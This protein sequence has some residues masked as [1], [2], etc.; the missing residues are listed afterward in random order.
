MSV[1]TRLNAHSSF[2]GRAS[3]FAALL[4]AAIAVALLVACDGGEDA[5]KTVT[6]TVVPSPTPSTVTPI[7]TPT[8]E[9]PT[10]PGS[11]AGVTASSDGWRRIDLSWTA[12]TDDGGSDVTGY[13]IEMSDDGA[14]WDELVADT[15][16]ESTEYAHVGL[17]VDTKRHY[18][19]SAINAVGVGSSS[20]IATGRAAPATAPHPPSDLKATKDEERRIDLSW[21]APVEDGGEVIIGYL[22][23]V[24][25]DG[26]DWQELASDIEGVDAAYSMSRW[27]WILPFSTGF[28]PSMPSERGSRRTSPRES[29]PQQ[30][31]LESRED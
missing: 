28:R 22:I 5:L 21:A 12:P 9:P 14:S 29:R 2:G 24:S 3:W 4:G 23:E 17:E 27:M 26:S 1:Q 6:P 30:P 11:P 7:I 25:E 20:N 19:V 8:D 31:C 15:R 18:R 10:P 16:D 13:R